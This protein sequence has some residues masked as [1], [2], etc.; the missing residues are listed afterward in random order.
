MVTQQTFKKNNS[1]HCARDTSY[2]QSSTMEDKLFASAPGSMHAAADADIQLLGR[3]DAEDS[4][5]VP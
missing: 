5:D 3:T 1:V 4:R 2:W